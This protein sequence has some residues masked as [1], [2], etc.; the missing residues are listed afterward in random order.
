MA[1]RGKNIKMEN[2]RTTV[3]PFRIC[4]YNVFLAKLLNYNWKCFTFFVQFA[5]VTIKCWNLPNLWPEQNFETGKV[6]VIRDF[7][8][9]AKRHGKKSIKQTDL[10][11][12]FDGDSCAMQLHLFTF[13]YPSLLLVH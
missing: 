4:L 11:I 2:D 6:N 13:D 10:S 9:Y 7:V 8:C 12:T 1:Q 5:L 3:S